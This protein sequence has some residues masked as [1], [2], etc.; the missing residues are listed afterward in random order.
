MK[1]HHSLKAL[2]K[3]AVISSSSFGTERQTH[4]RSTSPRSMKN[5]GT[6]HFIQFHHKLHR[7]IGLPAFPSFCR[8]IHSYWISLQ[9]RRQLRLRM[10]A[11]LRAPQSL[12][13]SIEIRSIDAPG[14]RR[15]AAAAEPSIPD[16]LR[17]TFY[18]ETSLLAF[19]Q[20][21]CPTPMNRNTIQTT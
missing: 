6:D 1:L 14:K 7:T 10:S 2:V 4:Q 8:L 21:L 16:C 9:E 5:I 19:P 15:I 18:S 13:S 11:E 17:G 12:S 3:K 20:N